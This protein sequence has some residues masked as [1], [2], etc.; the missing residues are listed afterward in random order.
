MGALDV[1]LEGG[2]VRAVDERDD[3]DVLLDEVVGRD[4]GGLA[5]GIGRRGRALRQGSGD[6]VERAA[7][8]R[9]G[10]GAEV[11]VQEVGDVGIVGAPAE[12]RQ[13]S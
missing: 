8:L 10:A 13:P 3:R 5:V 12:R 2:A 11:E 9:A 1:R 6:V 7:E 4:V